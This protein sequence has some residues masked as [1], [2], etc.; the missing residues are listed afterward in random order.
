M[1]EGQSYGFHT[2]GRSPC[3]Q[4]KGYQTFTQNDEMCN[5]RVAHFAG[6]QHAKKYEPLAVSPPLSLDNIPRPW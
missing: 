1:D 3:P 5:G 4:E 2:L 6:C